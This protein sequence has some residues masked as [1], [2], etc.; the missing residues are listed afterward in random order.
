MS[1][2]L[3]TQ[4]LQIP[5]GPR[6]PNHY[7]LLGLPPFCDDVHKIEE[8]AGR[9]LERLDRYALHPDTALREAGQRIM[10][11][12]ARARVVLA[13]A[14]KRAAY[15]RS[16]MGPVAV[17]PSQLPNNPP[18]VI[19]DEDG[20]RSST[21]TRLATHL[22]PAP[23]PPPPVTPIELGIRG[24]AEVVEPAAPVKVIPIG[25]TEV[26][27]KD[28]T[29]HAMHDDSHSGH[30]ATHEAVP[31][32]EG[33]A[34]E[35]PHSQLVEAAVSKRGVTRRPQRGRRLTGTILVVASL[36]AGVGIAYFAMKYMRLPNPPDSLN[37]ADTQAATSQPLG[38]PIGPPRII[39]PGPVAS[40]PGPVTTK[41]GP[42]A[43]TVPVH[44]PTT[45]PTATQK[46][47]DLI[48]VKDKP[49]PSATQPVT[50]N[51]LDHQPKASIPDA[52]ARQAAMKM[53]D[54]RFHDE[55]ASCKTR[56]DYGVLSQKLF[57]A[58][59]DPKADAAQ[60]FVLLVKAR[61]MAIWAGSIEMALQVVDEM[62]K[63]FRI[64][65]LQAK[66]DVLPGFVSAA[67]TASD[68]KTL[69]QNLLPLVDDAIKAERYDLALQ[70]AN[71]ALAE[72]RDLNDAAMA[73]QM[74]GRILE[75]QGA[76]AGYKAVKPALAVLVNNPKDPDANLVVGMYECVWKG[77]WDSG[78]K[79]LELSNDATLR[80]M[81]SRELNGLADANAQC[82]LADQW[83]DY[84][85]NQEGVV[86]QRW[87]AHAGVWYHQAL[88]NLA[89]VRMEKAQRRLDVLSRMALTATGML[90]NTTPDNA[91]PV[92]SASLATGSAAAIVPVK[93][94]RKDLAA[95]P[96][97]EAQEE[98][99]AEIQKSFAK[100]AAD[101][102]PSARPR[103]MYA[104]WQRSLTAGKGSPLQFMLLLESVRL[105]CQ[106]GDMNLIAQAADE[107]SKYFAIDVLDLKY[108]ALSH[109]SQEGEGAHI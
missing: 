69:L 1:A 42:V 6:P 39:S 27:A 58:G 7:A 49:N 109:A 63:S 77:N 61:D 45:E 56:D 51:N 67:K 84:A 66:A 19:D 25:V 88:P 83:W 81:A 47:S 38:T 46:T 30:D 71:E 70:L 101:P 16:L 13:S 60:R 87:R 11:E 106:N 14:E 85:E 107:L 94:S 40:R 64:D 20:L 23:P 18:S 89:G 104:V 24:V 41:P 65:P 9:Q 105:G 36:F 102:D 3:Y 108:Q 33:A 4:W 78:L 37:V 29:D 68:H 59:I 103:L 75:I 72:T 5:A 80:D 2:D 57:K 86:R 54:D 50:V 100:D 62:D 95:I 22:P 10:N 21:L 17:P 96:S 32:N 28:A 35:L 43:I 91:P 44:P 99:Q 55:I 15:N 8:A 31:H 26:A 97:P 90:A 82:A 12:V 52:A 74:T 53:L 48:G 34:V 98:A 76:A 92:V 93:A 79:R 73:Q